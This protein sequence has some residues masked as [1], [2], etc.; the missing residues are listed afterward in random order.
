MK[1]QTKSIFKSLLF[2]LVLLA[3]TQAFSMVPNERKVENKIDDLIGCEEGDN[4]FRHKG[5]L[6]DKANKTRH[7]YEKEELR[8]YQL[9]LFKNRHSTSRP[10]PI[11]Q[12]PLI[13]AATIPI[14]KSHSYLTGLLILTNLMVV[15]ALIFSRMNR[16]FMLNRNKVPEALHCKKLGCARRGFE[17]KGGFCQKHFKE[18][19]K[20]LIEE[21]AAF[22]E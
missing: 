10:E 19:Q 20:T 5:S 6:L 18:L 12:A 14:S 4:A 7:I 9:S 13:P 11:N 22:F 15:V 21:D 8:R 16:R 3:S 1:V 2:V 17:T